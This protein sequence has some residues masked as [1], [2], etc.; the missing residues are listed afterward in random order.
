MTKERKIVRVSIFLVGFVVGTLGLYFFN[1]Q[2]EKKNADLSTEN[3]DLF[4]EVA[5]LLKDHPNDTTVTSEDKLYGA[6]KGLVSAYDDP[7]S[8]FFTPE[9]EDAFSETI[10][11]EFV[12]VGMEIGVKENAITV[13]SPLKDSPAEKAGILPDDVILSVDQ[14]STDGLSVD[15]TIS[16]IKGDKGTEV[17]LALYRP[18]TKEFLDK[19]IIREVIQIPI[20]EKEMLSIG[21][22][23]VIY[24][25][26]SSFTEK[27]AEVLRKELPIEEVN[28]SDGLIIDLRYNPGGYLD[29]A[30]EISSM[31]LDQGELIVTEK[32][33]F[34]GEE[35]FRSLKKINRFS[36]D[37]PVVILINKG[38]A[39]ASEIFAAALQDHKRATVVGEQSFGKG[40]V[41]EYMPLDQGTAIKMTV[42]NWYRPNGESITDLGVTPDIIID[43]LDESGKYLPFLFG[44]ENDPFINKALE[45][46]SK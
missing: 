37:V 31:F 3:L 43:N 24:I 12:G 44:G 4:F 39:S 7:Y 36:K 25:S 30:I 6:I 17:T 11:G 5:K 15:Q 28:S 23:D 42:A 9:E 21:D 2:S 45:I 1:S 19:K 20:T 35:S 34:F 14:T 33:D 18:A 32:S 46:I 22:K 16:L 27:S 10:S 8:Q 29:Q 41:Q 13:I 38:S 26:M 40:S